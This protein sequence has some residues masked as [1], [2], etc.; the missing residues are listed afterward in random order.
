LLTK[1]INPKNTDNTADNIILPKYKRVKRVQAPLSTIQRIQCRDPD[2]LLQTDEQKYLNPGSWFYIVKEKSK[3]IGNNTVVITD[4]AN[5]DA[6]LLGLVADTAIT[7]RNGLY[8]IPV[9]VSGEATINNRSVPSITDTPMGYTYR[10]MYNSPYKA[11]EELYDE[12]RKKMDTTGTMDCFT[13]Q[14]TIRV[15][16][17]RRNYAYLN[18]C[19]FS[20]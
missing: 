13:I 3:D 6:E 7:K 18:V 11:L 10:H 20:I 17:L 8:I 19:I 12:D 9:I 2:L 15:V 1:Y 5:P 16:V 14:N 4:I